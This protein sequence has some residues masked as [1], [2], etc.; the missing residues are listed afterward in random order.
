MNKNQ[1]TIDQILEKFGQKLE[2]ISQQDRILLISYLALQIAN[3]ILALPLIQDKLNHF[4]S[5]LSREG[6]ELILMLNSISTRYYPAFLKC[7]ASGIVDPAPF[8]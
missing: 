3:P 1:I 7:L 2:K 5:Q 6:N 8:L 4:Q